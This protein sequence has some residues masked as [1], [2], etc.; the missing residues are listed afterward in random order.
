[1]ESKRK[2]LLNAT[3]H[4][5]TFV[6]EPV[7]KPGQIWWQTLPPTWTRESSRHKKRG[8]PSPS[9]DEKIE[10]EEDD[11]HIES[12]PMQLKKCKYM[13]YLTCGMIIEH[14]SCSYLLRMSI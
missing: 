14:K 5:P 11:D 1:M 10:E 12:E 6:A 4:S 2:Y 9:K 13:F 7:L 3:L 8:C